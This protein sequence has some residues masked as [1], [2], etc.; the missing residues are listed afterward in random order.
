MMMTMKI[1]VVMIMMITTKLITINM[2]KRLIRTMMMTTVIVIVLLPTILTMIP[3]VI[4]TASTSSII[5]PVAVRCTPLAIS[6]AI[7]DQPNPHNYLFLTRAVISM[8][9]SRKICDSRWVLYSSLFAF[10]T[11][12]SSFELCPQTLVQKCIA[13]YRLWFHKWKCAFVTAFMLFIC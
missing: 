1:M 4:Q 8:I 12:S 9:N 11:R 3:M 7:C 6:S 5:T 2:L 10:P 13:F